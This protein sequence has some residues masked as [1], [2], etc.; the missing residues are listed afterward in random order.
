[1]DTYRRWPVR[2]TD[3]RGAILIDSSGRE[4]ID[5]VAGIAVAGVGHAHPK[6]VQAISEQASRLIHVSNLYRT[7]PQERLAERLGS[8]TGGM[9]SFF[10]NSGAEAVECALKLA[11][12]RARKTKG[13]DAT[14]IISTVGG[15]H[16][17]TFGALAATGQPSKQAPFSP[18]VPGF[19]HVAYGDHQAL[20]EA[21]H[22]NVAAVII[23][24][25]QGENGVVVPPKG[26]LP[27][28][29]RLCKAF[30]ALLILDEVQTGI[31]RTGRW[32]GHEHFGV[33]PDV[34]CLA[35]ALG[36][37][38]PIGACLATPHVA[39]AFEFGDHGSTFG[40]GPVQCAA[41]LA[42]LDVMEEEG[43]VERAEYVGERLRKELDKV[44]G[45]DATV[46]GLGLMIGVEF[47]DPVAREICEK[48]LM[49]GL[50]VNNATDRVMRL[51]PPLVIT[52]EDI[53]KAIVILEEVWDEV[54]AA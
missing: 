24:P 2:F 10:C 40:G 38:L 28:A 14:S 48:A 20:S 49:K 27:F 19:T 21:M 42:V 3:G 52:N 43:L 47:T 35:K 31:G 16:G 36:G 30:K 37:G 44:F 4:Y 29:A 12:R 15:F 1:M 22:E 32:F 50:L 25:I 39:G 5:M 34:M 18:M 51:T 54:G 53:D 26:Y 11:R 23:E 41:A 9:S 45:G 7:D 13:P 33:V 17:R 6:V 46:R 8:L